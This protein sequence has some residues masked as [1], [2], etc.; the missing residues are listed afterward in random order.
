MG[1]QSLIDLGMVLWSVILVGI[2]GFRKEKVKIYITHSKSV[3]LKGKLKYL[4]ASLVLLTGSAL[5][6]IFLWAIL[7][8]GGVI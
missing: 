4:V 3:T 8:I 7:V 6:L 5:F 1:D 2:N